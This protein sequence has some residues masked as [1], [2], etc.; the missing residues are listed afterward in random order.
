ML[1]QSAGNVPRRADSSLTRPFLQDDGAGANVDEKRAGVAAG[2]GV[3]SERRILAALAGLVT[4]GG[5]GAVLYW[6]AWGLWLHDRALGAGTGCHEQNGR[7][8]CP[9]S[10]DIAHTALLSAAF[11]LIGTLVTAWVAAAVR[12]AREGLGWAAPGGQIGLAVRHGP[13]WLAVMVAGPLWT[14]ASIAAAV[15]FSSGMPGLTVVGSLAGVAAAGAAL[16]AGLACGG[17]TRRSAAS[18]PARCTLLLD[19]CLMAMLLRGTD[20]QLTLDVFLGMHIEWVWTAIQGMMLAVITA[21]SMQLICCTS[22]GGSARGQTAALYLADALAARCRESTPGLATGKG[23]PHARTRA[24]RRWWSQAL[25]LPLRVALLQGAYAAMDKSSGRAGRLVPPNTL[26]PFVIS[27]WASTAVSVCCLVWD[28]YCLTVD[29]RV[30]L[31][32][33]N[34][35][36]HQYLP[37]EYDPEDA[38][39]KTDGEAPVAACED[40]A[41]FLAQYTFW[42]VT[43][44]L[45]RANSK[46]RLDPGDTPPLPASDDPKRL[47]RALRAIIAERR[48][49]GSPPL[50]GTAMLATVLFR[51]QPWVFTRC[52]VHGWVF[53]GCMFLDP[54]ILR[55]LL[56]SSSSSEN[57]LET[58]IFLVALLSV[59]M[60]V[61]VSCME[62]C[63]FTSVRT[64]SNARSAL[65]Q[66]VYK[67]ALYMPARCGGRYDTGK[68]TNLVATDSD[69]FAKSEWIVFF[70]AQWTWA[71]VSLPAII[72][73][74]YDLVG[75][76]A[77]IGMSTILLG[78]FTSF[79]ISKV[80]QPVYKRVQEAR[81]FR[82][83]LLNGVV[84]TI[85]AIKLQVCELLWHGR[86]TDARNVE[87][88]HLKKSRYWSAFNNFVGM[89]C[90]LAVPVSIFSWYTT[91]EGKALNPT[92]AFT[93]LA[94]IL[95]M[96]WSINTLPGMFNLYASLNPS[97]ER[98]SEFLHAAGEW[99]EAAQNAEEP[100][101]G[102][103]DSKM[104][105]V[106][107][108]GDMGYEVWPGS[109]ASEQDGNVDSFEGTQAPPDAKEPL[110]QNRGGKSPTAPGL[111]SDLPTSVERRVVLSGVNLHIRQ[112]ELVIVT[113]DVG[114][115]KT[116]LL[117]TVARAQP[118]LA[119]SVR[120]LGSRAYVSQ[121]PF[122]LN[123]TIRDNVV[124]GSAYE[125]ERYHMVLWAA[126]L[127][128]DLDAL[129]SRDETIVGESGVQMSGGQKARIA[130]ARALYADA[131][132][133]FLDDVLSA[134][135]AHTGSLVW[136]RCVVDLVRRGR[137]LVLATH[138]VQYLSRPEVTRV[139]VLAG[140]RI[141]LDGPWKTIEEKAGDAL[142]RSAGGNGTRDS[143]R[144]KNAQM[145]ASP[146]QDIKSSGGA[147][148]SKLSMGSSSPKVDRI[149]GACAIQKILASRAVLEIKKDKNNLEVPLEECVAHMRKFLAR[150]EGRSVD[151]SL[152]NDLQDSM[153]GDADDKETREEGMVSWTDFRV[154]LDVFGTRATLLALALLL[155]VGP[156]LSAMTNVW[157]SVWA[158]RDQG[159]RQGEQDLLIY[160]AFG[161]ADGLVSALSNIIVTL[162]ALRASRAIHRDMLSSL[163]GAELQFF[164]S[165]PSGRIANR[166]LQD[167]QSIDAFVPNSLMQMS[168]QTLSLATMLIL[169][170][171]YAPFS[172]VSLVVLCPWYYSI[173]K[174]VRTANRDARRLHSIAHSPCYAHFSDTLHGRKTVR[175]FGAERR[176]EGKSFRLVRN[177]A[178][179]KYTNEAV[180]KWLQALTTQAG[181][182]L[183]FCCGI[184]CVILNSKGRITTAEMGLVLLYAGTLQRAM[185]DFLTGLNRVEMN[186]I[187]VERVAEYTRLNSDTTAAESAA[188]AASATVDAK[189][190]ASGGADIDMSAV[191]MRYR[192]HK[193]CVLRGL[194]LSVRRG[195]SVALCG[196]TGCGKST[197]FSILT[198]L[199]PI[200]KGRVRID[201]VD[202]HD[203][204][205]QRVRSMVRVVD[206]DAVL[207]SG[208]LKHNVVGTW[209]SAEAVSAVPDERVWAVLSQVGMAESVRTWPGGLDFEVQDGGSNLSSGE[210]QLVALARA[211][212]S[213]SRARVLLC[214]EATAH[215]DLETDERVHDVILSLKGT[216]VVMICHRLQHIHRFDRVV[217]LD[218]GR[219]V[220]SGAPRKLLERKDSRLRRLYRAA[221][222]T[223]PP[224][225]V[226]SGGRAQ[227]RVSAIMCHN[228]TLRAL[229]SPRAAK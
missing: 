22:V 182:I 118:M 123:G 145:A 12:G 191:F 33:T 56:S 20:A 171:V 63:Y 17:F 30:S 71:V 46:G 4:L 76:A 52:M 160:A 3:S 215:V 209:K 223:L 61:R 153:M 168:L 218:K 147:P 65:V 8:S 121:K 190:V 220:E 2:A 101:R 93:A 202:I 208:S 28:A 29:P 23:D 161:V 10:T 206:Q 50:S 184:T 213:S 116:T 84:K 85:R 21:R 225:K 9:K 68:L 60:V 111:R 75:T 187:S 119:G 53:L 36:R 110:L 49:R 173:F 88:E 96:Q 92:V 179:G 224:E 134:V 217:V 70:L 113:G 133:Y 174:R 155:L 172:L 120:A 135:D 175:A 216:T 203:L 177:M 158:N 156:V 193:P 146:E 229:S 149:A 138:Q 87:L 58:N 125:E 105:A 5:L 107:A 83:Q 67:A 55:Q 180:N 40:R 112:G 13:S 201:G 80:L 91:Y 159:G 74:V 212:L 42:W 157:L 192:L 127:G 27:L 69:K 64:M 139:L 166:F 115:G 226:A 183:Y 128:P 228:A 43:P 222:L 214:D 18:L 77:Y 1:Q 189:G 24:W 41:G 167:L 143:S 150:R 199:Y 34:G 200:S 137:T 211:L 185:M 102:G 108:T 188:V 164:D 122:L 154:Y 81:D 82:S 194:D 11:L 169:V 38:Y 197:L 97:C 227:R 106:V 89:L 151:A 99:G 19:T 205:P 207:I 31:L 210:R 86:V 165:T 198:R 35:T 59:S 129:E 170:F 47:F 57:Q 117:S 221:K 44:V 141:W 132:L 136:D 140:G 114:T 130:L 181:C 90:S 79:A 142:A 152:V 98:L 144:A 51:I 196:R 103:R 162:C 62:V 25:L 6:T 78:T 39:A 163:L 72:Y 95:N 176:F 131:D 94:W 126:V 104:G 148:D 37:G 124:F 32:P 195:E 14:A 73:F 100:S 204:P 15:S 109:K 219:V 178:R 45:N 186:F 26:P 48:E 7:V 66:S 54:I 16:D